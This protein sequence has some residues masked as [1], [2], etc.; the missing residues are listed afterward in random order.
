MNALSGMEKFSHLEDKIYLTIQF[1]QKLR[2]EKDEVARELS[3]LRRENAS[4]S[5]TN[6][7]LESKIGVLMN[8]RDA[9]HLKVESMLDAMTEI[10]ADV[11][12]AVGR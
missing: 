8:E 10:D 7:E 1:A 9:I 2:E 12:D 4:L 11:A 6:N 5:E 3:V